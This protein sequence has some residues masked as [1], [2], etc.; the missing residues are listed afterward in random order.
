MQTVN[1]VLQTAIHR[2]EDMLKDDDGQARKEAR[3]FIEALEQDPP[4]NWRTP[5]GFLVQAVQVSASMGLPLS[6]I[7]AGSMWATFE[8]TSRVASTMVL[9][10]IPL[11]PDE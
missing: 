5:I 11:Q 7:A 10:G 4:K 8:L 9:R 1:P 2:I 6:V 3:K